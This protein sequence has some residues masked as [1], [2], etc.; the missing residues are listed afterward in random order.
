MGCDRQDLHACKVDTGVTTTTII[1][2]TTTTTTIPA[3]HHYGGY[4]CL[5]DELF[6]NTDSSSPTTGF[7]GKPCTSDSECPSIGPSGEDV[8][9]MAKCGKNFPGSKRAGL[10]YLQCRE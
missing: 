2:T 3:T 10:C 5:T 8:L 6:V 4:P 9:K 1:T 7:C